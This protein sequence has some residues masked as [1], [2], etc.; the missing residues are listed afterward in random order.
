ML[1]KP[2]EISRLG[3]AL[4]VPDAVAIDRLARVDEVARIS[5]GRSMSLPSRVVNAVI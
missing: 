1:A 5:C 4:R 3:S 2:Y